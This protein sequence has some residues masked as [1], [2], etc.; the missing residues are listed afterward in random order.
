[1]DKWESWWET[2]DKGERGERSG[3]EGRKPVVWRTD[4]EI[5]I[6]T[7]FEGPGTQEHCGQENWSQESKSPGSTSSCSISSLG[8][9]GI[10]TLTP[11]LNSG[12]QSWVLSNQKKG[13]FP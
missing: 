2:Q 10:C 13:L 4:R 3:K 11:A 12:P 8:D 5:G 6:Y 7:N 9:C 1:M